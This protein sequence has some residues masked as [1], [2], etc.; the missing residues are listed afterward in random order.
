MEDCS[1]SEVVMSSVLGRILEH[2]RIE[3]DAAKLARPLA[4]FESG[5]T[6]ST[7]DFRAALL[8]PG[9]RFI[10]E[11]KKGSPSRGAIRPD[12][13]LA[14]LLAT[15]DNH[16]D[17]ISVLTDTEFFGG[18]N[19]DLV[20]AGQL[21]VRP[22]LRKDFMIDPYQIAEAR[23]LG[24][25]C[26]LLIVSALTDSELD[27][28]RRQAISLGMDALVEVHDETE[29]ERALKLGADLIGINNRN[30]KTLTTDLGVTEKLAPMVPEGVALVGESG[31]GTHHD[32]RRLASHVD[33]FLV[34]SAILS[35]PDMSA[36]VRELAYGRVKICG[37]TN[38]ADADAALKAG[39]SWLGFIFHRGSPRAVTPE[40][41][42]E[43]V[44]GLPGTKVGVFVDH[45]LDEIEAVARR[46]RL[47][48]VQ[49]HG[50]Y[51]EDDL[52]LM[53]GR[54]DDVFL[55]KVL[56]VADK[57]VELPESQADYFLLDTFDPVLRG[58]TGRSF[59][60]DLLQRLIKDD[61]QRF[62]RQVILAG[63]LN[64]GN[65]TRAAE[66]GPFAL[67]LASG[68][69]AEPGRKDLGKLQELFLALRED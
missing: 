26:I 39:A 61:P 46:S 25:D 20:R 53:K 37:L 38:R 32:V 34:G 51:S 16:A 68:V 36:K 13:D 23:L 10:F 19:E 44:R 63:G 7:R 21:T 1:I 33:A 49:L 27:E 22:L 52:R 17:C 6:P 18:C 43:I 2:K 24:A 29:M 28:M 3:V 60:H 55:I 69:E 64:P 54:L 42:E 50:D 15:Y 41:C 4:T 58:G 48:G 65:V 40:R 47:H 11:V 5:L 31:L 56:Q 62:G 57:M 9:R 30:L 45:T 12:L 14:S 67:D 66:L 8:A 35:A 59:N